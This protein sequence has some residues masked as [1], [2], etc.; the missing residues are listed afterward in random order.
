[1]A[2]N[3]GL[4]GALKICGISLPAE[5]LSVFQELCLT[6]NVNMEPVT[7]TEY[8]YTNATSEFNGG[9]VTAQTMNP[10]LI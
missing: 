8:I 5:L 9:L 3:G 2:P 6:D 7:K 4:F 10:S 1:M